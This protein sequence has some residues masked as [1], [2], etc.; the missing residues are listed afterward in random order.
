MRQTLL[1]RGLPRKIYL[2]H[3]PAVRSHHLEKITASLGIALVHSL[4]Y[5]PQSRGKVE[6]FFRTVRSQFLPGFK[7]DT[8]RGINEAL[9]CWIRDIY[10]QRK[11][12]G[13]GQAPL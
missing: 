3:G 7:G 10:Y 13:T 1:K 12:L 5:V 9:E 8:L 11:H 2:D 4:H 6:R